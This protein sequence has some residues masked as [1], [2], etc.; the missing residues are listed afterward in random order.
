MKKTETATPR[1]PD[2]AKNHDFTFR[3]LYCKTSDKSSRY[4]AA[5]EVGS[6][7]LWMLLSSSSPSVSKQFSAQSAP[8]PAAEKIVW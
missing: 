1:A 3:Q 8:A 4:F 6:V 5:V 7:K 2:G